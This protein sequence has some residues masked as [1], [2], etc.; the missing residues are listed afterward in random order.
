MSAAPTS[1]PTSASKRKRII[2]G[3]GRRS[4]VQ[5]EW[6]E[7][8]DNLDNIDDPSD[9]VLHGV[10]AGEGGS[11]SGSGGVH[12]PAQ[13]VLPPV[14]GQAA[15]DDIEDDDDEDDELEFEEPTQIE[16]L[17]HQIEQGPA[18]PRILYHLKIDLVET[19][20]DRPH[21]RSHCEEAVI[22]KALPVIAA[23]DKQH[24]LR[25]AL[26]QNTGSTSGSVPPQK[27]D[28]AVSLL[29]PNAPPSKK[30]VSFDLLGCDDSS[31]GSVP[32]QK[33]ESLQ[34][35]DMSVQ[36]PNAPPS[37]KQVSLPDPNPIPNLIPKPSP[38]PTNQPKPTNPNHPNR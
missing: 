35:P 21:L 32:T 11:G 24:K 5:P 37:K 17:G 38:T 10:A 26:P 8:D 29:A 16:V 25:E 31:S 23:Y 6:T 20:A 2:E 22:E 34:P 30:Q 28:R 36:P 27:R 3:A 13:P 4:S 18:G 33:T 12:L 9:G 19:W 14:T 7:R 15:D 1:A